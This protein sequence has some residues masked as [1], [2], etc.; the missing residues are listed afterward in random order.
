VE[1][2]NKHDDINEEF[3]EN[4]SIAVKNL[5][6]NGHKCCCSGYEAD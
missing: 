5:E 4:A 6:K 1:K 3:E 2:S